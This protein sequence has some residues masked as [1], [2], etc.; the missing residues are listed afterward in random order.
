MKNETDSREQNPAPEVMW[1]F[2]WPA[3]SSESCWCVDLQY[4]GKF[5]VMIWSLMW[6]RRQVTQAG[7]HLQ[8]AG[9]RR[10]GCSKVCLHMVMDIYVH[11]GQGVEGSVHTGRA[12]QKRSG[13]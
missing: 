4:R 6:A 8:L 10:S 7:S 2:T 1:G 13:V 3:R 12:G 11:G 9:G 5:Q